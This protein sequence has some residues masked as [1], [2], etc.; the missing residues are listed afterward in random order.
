MQNEISEYLIKHRE[1]YGR[2]HNQKEQMAYAVSV[3]Y[4]A[5][6]SAL[7]LE[8]TKLLMNQYCPVKAWLKWHNILLIHLI[9]PIF[10]VI[11]LDFG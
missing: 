4:L 7:L 5:A 10:L 8:E 3:L 6:C 11:D 9:S 2:Y 1:L